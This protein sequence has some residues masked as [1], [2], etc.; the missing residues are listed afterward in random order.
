MGLMIDK[1]EDLRLE[2][3]SVKNPLKGHVVQQQR[4]HLPSSLWEVVPRSQELLGY[5][6]CAFRDPNVRRMG[7]SPLPLPVGFRQSTAHIRGQS[8]GS[9]PGSVAHQPCDEDIPSV[10][11]SGS[12]CII[13]GQ[14]LSE[15]HKEMRSNLAWPLVG[16]VTLETEHLASIATW[17]HTGCAT[18]VQLLEFSGLLSPCV[19]DGEE[20][21]AMPGKQRVSPESQP[22]VVTITCPFPS[23]QAIRCC[24]P[25][26][27]VH[28][29]LIPLY[30]THSLKFL[31]VLSKK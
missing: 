11:A 7:K 5:P 3:G 27:D 21:E 14:L 12:V 28:S 20:E 1:L 26:G 25:C 2:S 8:L 4:Q 31:T 22:A 24:P 10:W 29:F 18:L 6:C 23:S 17:L 16:D 13:L 30:F 15:A 19:D 9:N